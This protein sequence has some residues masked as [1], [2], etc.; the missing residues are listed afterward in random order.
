MSTPQEPRRS[1]AAIRA[2]TAQQ[3]RRDARALPR[4]TARDF[5]AEL[6]YGLAKLMGFVVLVGGGA[7]VGSAVGGVAATLVGALIGGALFVGVGIALVAS[8]IVV[9]ARDAI[10]G[11]TTPRG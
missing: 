7:L 5:V 2:A 11:R 4:E 6:A 3:L 1:A 8:G 9:V 10:A